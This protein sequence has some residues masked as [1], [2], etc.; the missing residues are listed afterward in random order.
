MTSSGN[1]DRAALV[2]G[3]RALADFIEANPALPVPSYVSA[4][5]SV[6]APGGDDDERR[7]FVDSAAAALG[8][9]A[10][11]AVPSGHYTTTRTFGPVGFSA[12]MVPAAAHARHDA[13]DSY[14]D[15]IRLDQPVA[16]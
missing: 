13:L 6:P 4:R 12:F 5:V 9:T 10:A 7:T 3:L 8:T 1:D 11:Y 16:A 2:D 14:R 15:S